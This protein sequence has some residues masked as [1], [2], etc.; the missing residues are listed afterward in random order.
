MLK[1]SI[2]AIRVKIPIALITLHMF[3]GV[4]VIFF[5][6]FFEIDLIFFKEKCMDNG[7]SKWFAATTV[8]VFCCLFK[9]GICKEGRL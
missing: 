4:L 8:D 2:E 7:I 3:L 9:I 5:K 6:Y 1:N